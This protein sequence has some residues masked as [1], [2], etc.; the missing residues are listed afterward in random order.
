[1]LIEPRFRRGVERLIADHVHA[2]LVELPLEV[3]PDF[4]LAGHQP[5]GLV[6]DRRQLLADGHAF[7][8]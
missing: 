7:G 6:D 1:M 3:A 2:R 4:V 5:V 8:R